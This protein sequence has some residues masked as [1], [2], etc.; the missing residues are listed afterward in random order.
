MAASYTEP[1][2]D[3]NRGMLTRVSAEYVSGTVEQ[4]AHPFTDVPADAWY[5]GAVA[6]CRAG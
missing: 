1:E 5:A 6:Y 2:N 3:Q 4:A